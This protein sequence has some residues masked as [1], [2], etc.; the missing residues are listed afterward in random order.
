MAVYNLGSINLDHVYRV[1][2]L[3]QPGETL[4]AVD[5]TVGLGGKGA[6]QSVAVAK[7]GAAIRHIGC[8][9]REGTWALGR[10]RDYGVD[11]SRVTIG[12]QPTGHAIINVD[13]D[14]ENAIVIFPG[15]NHG[16]DAVAMDEALADGVTGDTL[17]I[18]NET[19][20]QVEAAR[21]AQ[22]KRMF[23]VYSA[24]P[25]DA[26]A[27][28]AILPH[29]SLLVVNEGEAAQLQVALNGRPEVDMVITRGSK[30]AEWI[31]VGAEPVF[32]P[33]FRVTPVDTTGAGDTFIGTLVA[34]IDLGLSRVEAMRRAAAAAA[35][36]VTRPGAAQAIPTAQEVNA[37]L[38]AQ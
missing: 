11:V 37:F 33:A 14:G 9:G 15:A 2:H 24:A 16:I 35:L 28:R 21:I 36:Q 30:G 38:D 20:L 13:P 4:S 32:Q 17:M 34:G 27:V 18:Q 7:A 25:F 6:N 31:S 1:P 12:E 8:V 29:V 10:L 26:E 3:P 23:V 19:S 22:Q 5:Y